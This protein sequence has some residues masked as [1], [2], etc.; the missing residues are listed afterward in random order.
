MISAVAA[1]PATIRSG[2]SSTSCWPN[3][4][5]STAGNASVG[6]EYGVYLPY[7]IVSAF[8]YASASLIRRAP[9]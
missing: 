8:A 9:A 1:N 6:I 5:I 4:S 3:S 7:S 2:S